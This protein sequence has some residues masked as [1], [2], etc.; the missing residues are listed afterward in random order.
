MSFVV[1]DTPLL[2]V[3][4]AGYG[5]IAGE[6]PGIVTLNDVPG[7]AVIDLLRRYDNAWLRREYSSDDGSYR[8]DRMPLNE[9][10]DL[11]ARDLT[12]T[13]DDVIIG[14]VQPYAPPQ[15][16]TASLAFTVGN[17]ATAEMARQYGWGPF[18]WS[19]TA[20]PPGLSLSA[21]G[22]WSG[23]PTTAGSTAATITVTDSYGEASSK[24]FN[25]V[26]T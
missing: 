22:A 23:T 20:L 4:H 25:V 6:T 24:A 2:A 3:P 8:F 26:V 11:V 15:I 13:W 9:T 1:F 19:I 10:Y 12:D 14:R 16:T 5:Y 17:P 7:V 18:T 21:A